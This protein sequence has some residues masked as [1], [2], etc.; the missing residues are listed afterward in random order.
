MFLFPSLYD[1]RESVLVHVS[2]P[3]GALRSEFL[4][5]YTPSSLLKQ[6]ASS[7]TWQGKRGVYLFIRA[8]VNW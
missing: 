5:W 2:P 4:A 8:A 1:I 6:V 7:F 3:G